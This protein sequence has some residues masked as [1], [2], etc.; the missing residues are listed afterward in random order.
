[1]SQE[2]SPAPVPADPPSFGRAC[3]SRGD[4]VADVNRV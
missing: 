3:G 1:M 4:L 2:C